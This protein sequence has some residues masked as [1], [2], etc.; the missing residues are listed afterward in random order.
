MCGPVQYAI[1]LTPL[2][3]CC[4]MTGVSPSGILYGNTEHMVAPVSP[5][6]RDPE[7]GP[8]RGNILL[9]ELRVL[10]RRRARLSLLLWAQLGAL[11]GFSALLCITYQL[12][13]LFEPSSSIAWAIILRFA[14][15]PAHQLLRQRLPNRPNLAALLSTGVV[16]LAVAIPVAVI[17][18]PYARSCWRRG[19]C[20]TFSPDRWART[21]GRAI[22]RAGMDSPVEMAESM[23]GYDV[24]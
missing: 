10:R 5:P 8:P 14:F 12:Y 24:D 18:H 19:G 13:Q 6:G 21:L 20:D 3:L 4:S 1:G 9:N 17:E 2:Q 7:W 23:A 11:L 15:Q 16:M 22:A